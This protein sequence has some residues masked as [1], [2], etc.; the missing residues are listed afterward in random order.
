ML[1]GCLSV[2]LCD[3]MTVISVLLLFVLKSQVW[4]VVSAAILWSQGGAATLQYTCVAVS[5]CSSSQSVLLCN[6]RCCVIN[7]S[8]V[9][10]WWSDDSIRT[11]KHLTMFY[12]LWWMWLF[13]GCRCHGNTLISVVTT[14]EIIVFQVKWS[15]PPHG[16]M[17]LSPHR[18]FWSLK[19]HKVT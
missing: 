9:I 5:L 8:T 1:N 14:Q 18:C 16:L 12:V 7:N 17:I 15:N 6:M 10:N 19:T 11:Q 4:T 2:Y 13:T 3:N